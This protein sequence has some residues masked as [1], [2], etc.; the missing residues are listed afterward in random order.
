MR[1]V[2]RVAAEVRSGGTILTELRS[3]P[4][5][6]IRPTR[7]GIALVGSAAAP[8]GG[9]ESTLELDVGDGAELFVEAVAATIVYPG[10]DQRPSRQSISIRVGERGHLNWSSQ[11]VISVRRSHHIQRVTIDLASTATLHFD[12]WLAL[13]R[14]GEPSG[15]VDTELRV[16]RGGRPLL[17]QRQIIDPL[18]PR[19]QTTAGHGGF[20]Q[21]RQQVVVG[22]DASETKAVVAQ[23]HAEMRTPLADDAELTL[24][25][26]RR[27]LLGRLQPAVD[28][29]GTIT[30]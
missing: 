14:S 27:P 2:S 20:D 29:H 6:T 23:H 19:S 26:S 10:R 28:R 16:T 13:G 8:V 3:E 15:V 1:S 11:P 18:D 17:H 25:L 22:G 21:I 5:L 7:D 24:S 30:G 9:D 12:D 4:P